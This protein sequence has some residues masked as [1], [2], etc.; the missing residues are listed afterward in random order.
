M[1]YR[2]ASILVSFLFGACAI[3]QADGP[4]PPGERLPIAAFGQLPFVETAA[5]APDGAHWAGILGINGRENV[6]ILSL[7]DKSERIV[8]MSLPD[9]TEALWLHWVNSDNLL[10]GVHMLDSIQGQDFYVSRTFAVN[11]L[12]GKMTPI[13]WDVGGQH[14]SN[15]LWWPHDE[16]NEVLIAAQNSIYEGEDWWPAVHRVNV[17]NG[18][19][20]VVV[21]PH[22][23]IVDWGADAD[24]SVR[25]G[26]GYDDFHETSRLV[27]RPAGSRDSFR[28]VDRADARK[29]EG[30]RVPFIYLPDG[31]GL[32]VHDDERGMS[33]IYEV[34]LLTQAEVRTVYVAPSGEVDDVVVGADGATLLGVSNTSLHAG[35]HWFDPELLALQA[36]FDKAVPGAS[37]DIVSLSRDRKTM[38]VLIS[39][40]DMPGAI[41]YYSVSNGMLHRLA[42]INDRIG[43]TNHLAPVRVVSY[44][45]RDGLE[46]EAVLTLP[47]GRDPHRLPF[48][49]LPHG[50]PWAQDTL[51]YDYLVQFLANR[52]Y[53]V[54]Q[55]NYRGSTGY[56][57]AF[58][59]KG[60][61]QLGLAM[62]DD[63]TDGV[64]WAV[65]RQIAD[66]GRVCIVGGSYGGYAAMW[67]I[68][69]DPAQ[70][71][72]AISIAG[73]S[74]LRREVNDFANFASGHKFTDD[75][76]R[77][78]PD[79][80]AVSPIKA[81]ERIRT[82]LLLIHGKKDITVAHAQSAK[83][84][85][86]MKGAG[87][88]VEFV[89]LPLADHHFQRQED[90][91]A[92]LAA[93]ES[94]LA[95][96]NPVNKP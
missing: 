45:A 14:A 15:V 25:I 70:Y 84:Y 57:T 21:P 96:Y 27:Y 31:H 11:R 77:M 74:S 4:A 72:C 68:A 58:L 40:A 8:R 79:F 18:H 44:Q 26:I 93:M 36:A 5:L 60:E 29:R 56:G 52:G 53:A 55:P 42:A 22:G 30:L 71:R 80:D 28:T 51:R 66:A 82:P 39:A 32:V 67:G 89:S 59:R 23:G 85:E 3:A 33:A 46:I 10:V 78:T 49:V 24:G 90:R 94:F 83:M 86:R 1:H 41:Y 37:A 61:G 7:F 95:R 54:L 87:K 16:G 69:R 76:K 6:A 73:V 19:E 2:P 88:T 50:G 62:Q 35:T 81:V 20:H 64:R 91:I 9:G 17:T 75:W 65:G 48:I 92:M 34:D 63:I 43:P 12:S 47:P 38:L 13:L